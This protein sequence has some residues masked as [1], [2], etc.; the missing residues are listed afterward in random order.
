LQAH[1]SEKIGGHFQR[2][3]SL[4]ELIGGQEKV[5]ILGGGHVLKNMIVFAV[6]DEI[7]YGRSEAVNSQN[8]KLL[9]NFY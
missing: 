5:V 3:D 9:P 8:A 4:G 7:S 1:H 2:K 6:V